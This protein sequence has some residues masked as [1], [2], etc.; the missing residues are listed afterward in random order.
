MRYGLN[1]TPYFLDRDAPDLNFQVTSFP[2]GPSG[3]QRGSTV[4][5]NMYSISATSKN[6]GLAWEFIAYY[7]SLRGNIGIFEA[8]DYVTSPR[9]DFYRSR[10]W[11]AARSRHDWMPLVPEIAYVGG[12]YPFLES[13][14]LTHQV[15]NPLMRPALMGTAPVQSSFT[16]AAEI[17]DRFLADMMPSK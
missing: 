5:G 14:R 9:L 4:W 15:W 13:H 16:Q 12:V 11:I 1:A 2:Q 6:P 8:L 7:A 3:T 17:Y 10:Q